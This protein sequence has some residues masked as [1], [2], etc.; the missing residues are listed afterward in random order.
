VR[1]NLTELQPLSAA[2]TSYTPTVAQGATSNIAKT[3]TY[4]KYLLVG[5]TV[6]VQVNLGMT[7][8]GTSTNAI[9]CT[10][11]VAA[12]SPGFRDIGT[13]SY[14]AGGA[15]KYRVAACFNASATVLRFQYMAA[16]TD[17]VLGASGAFTGA[18]ASGHSLVFSVFYEAA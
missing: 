1:D 4:A 18:V 12:A 11:P 2:W 14:F 16:N 15:N 3:T 6:M 7:G 10:V 8:T 17:D 9:T 13:G 5:K